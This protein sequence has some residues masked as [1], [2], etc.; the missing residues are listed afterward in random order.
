MDSADAYVANVFSAFVFVEVGNEC[1]ARIPEGVDGALGGAFEQPFEF[2]EGQLDGIEVGIIRR[3]ER[4]RRPGR[5]NRLADPD[6]LVAGEIVHD[7]D[8][9]R[10][11]GR[12]ELLAHV[13]QEDLAVNRAIRRPAAR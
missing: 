4:Q 13:G 5:F 3:Q 7:D 10:P 12:K 6:A 2:G 9:A 1:A 11:Q 8:V